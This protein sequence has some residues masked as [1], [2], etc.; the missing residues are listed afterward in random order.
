MIVAGSSV[1]N[2]AEPAQVILTLRRS[3]ERLGHGKE[4]RDL[5]P[6]PEGMAP[7]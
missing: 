7:S 3:V 5:T 4:E 6:W 1:F 2:S